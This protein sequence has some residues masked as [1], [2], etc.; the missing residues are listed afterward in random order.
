MSNS[1]C[2]CLILKIQEI[3]DSNIDTTLFILYDK[4]DEY[5]I[6]TG[7]RS[8]INGTNEPV[9]YKFY[10]KNATEL[11]EFISIVICKNSTINYTL[12][13]YHD[14]PI[15]SDEIEF[16]YL[17]NLDGDVTYELAGYDDKKYN[18]QEILKYLRILK[19]VFNYY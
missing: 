14:L 4:N 8:N 15:N 11:I 6:V 12:Y 3:F 1:N 7:K 10:C 2:D 19:N 9:P 17:A 13:N 16:N 5:Y 18:K